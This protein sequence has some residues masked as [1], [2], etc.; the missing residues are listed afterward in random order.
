MPN[1]LPIL[2]F[3]HHAVL[4]GTLSYFRLPLM[5]WKSDIASLEIFNT[6]VGRGELCGLP[7]LRDVPVGDDIYKGTDDN[8]RFLF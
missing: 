8:E 7:S 4:E 6:M 3:H 2:V 5:S 1:S